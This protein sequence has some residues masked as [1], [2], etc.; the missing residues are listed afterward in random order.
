MNK[1]NKYESLKKF[2]IPTGIVLAIIFIF[3]LFIYI[4]ALPLSIHIIWNLYGYITNK[5]VSTTGVSQFLAK[6]IVII[7]LIPLIWVIPNMFKR[8]HRKSASAIGFL[9]IGVFFLA[10]FFLS[11]DIYFAHSGGEPLKWYALTPDG[12]RYYD[13]PGVDPVSGITLKPVTPEIIPKLKLWEKGALNFQLIDPADATWFNPITGDP[14][15]WYY[16]YPDGTLEFYNKP[17]HHPITG[18]PLKAVT[19]QIYF[20]WRE[21]TKTKPL[22]VTSQEY[23]EGNKKG[24]EQQMAMGPRPQISEKERRLQEFKSLINRVSNIHPG[25]PNIAMVI[26]SKRT[27]SGVSPENSLYNLLKTERANIIVN[28]FKEESF[29][30]KGFFR[31]IYDGNTELLRQTDALSKIDS[32]ILG[33]LNYSFSKGTGIDRDMVSCNINFSYKVINKKGDIIK[34]DSISVVG[35]GF[36]EDAALERGLEILSEKNSERIFKS[37]I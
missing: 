22:S 37:V 4:T 32:L 6:G 17:A 33:R 7:L 5:I 10:L 16:Q 15:L 35:P 23:S 36:S 2:L 9:Y 20:E 27:E 13:S 26:E 12:V 28:L 29:K 34:S 25:K 21:K 18:E 11:K 3:A 31:E 24:K 30:A 14:Q 19:K 8:K 1:E